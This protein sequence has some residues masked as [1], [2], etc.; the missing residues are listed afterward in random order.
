MTRAAERA[1]KTRSAWAELAI[2]EALADGLASSLRTELLIEAMQKDQRATL[3]LE[4]KLAE[5]LV[6]RAETLG[7]TVTDFVMLS[8]IARIETELGT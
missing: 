2:G 1:A 3:R 7:L 5:K 6:S 8:A 4:E